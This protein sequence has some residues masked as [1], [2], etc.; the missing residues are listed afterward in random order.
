MSLAEQIE[1]KELKISQLP[2]HQWDYLVRARRYY[3]DL[4]KKA[5]QDKPYAADVCAS[6][7]QGYLNLLDCI[8]SIG[9]K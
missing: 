1:M 8:L 7:D 5:A 3:V 6:I 2:D 4:E 9:Q